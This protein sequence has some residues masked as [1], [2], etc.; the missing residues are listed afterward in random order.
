ML[1]V[2]CA[3]QDVSSHEL[4]QVLVW[5]YIPVTIPSYIYDQT[6]EKHNFQLKRSLRSVLFQVLKS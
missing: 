3:I 4:F 2:L 1:S 5:L 6:E